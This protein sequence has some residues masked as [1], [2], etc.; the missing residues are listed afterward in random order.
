VVYSEHV[1][2]VAL[3]SGAGATAS[4]IG[5]RKHPGS[6]PGARGWGLKTGGEKPEAGVG[7]GVPPRPIFESV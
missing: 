2:A 5:I 1:A 3:G 7:M 4:N 6:F